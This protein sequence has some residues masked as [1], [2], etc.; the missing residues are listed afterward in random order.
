MPSSGYFISTFSCKTSG[1]GY[2]A[3][4]AEKQPSIGEERQLS[5]RLV[6]ASE[7]FQKYD[8]KGRGF[9][10]PLQLA[11]VWA[12]DAVAIVSRELNCEEKLMVASAVE[13]RFFELS[14]SSTTHVS[15]EE[16]FHRCL[17]DAHP[18]GSA[19]VRA[20]ADKARELDED[21][22][23]LTRDWESVD[24]NC[25]GRVFEEDLEDA[26]SY[27][28]V[29]WLAER[30][31]RELLDEAGSHGVT[32]ADFCAKRL[33]LEWA[34]VELHFYD[35]SKRFADCLSPLLLG[36]HEEGIWHTSVVAFGQEYFYYG[37]IHIQNP[38][39]T[40][41]GVP[42]RTLKLGKTLRNQDE[43]Q[44]VC[45]D[46]LP[47]FQPELYDPLE[48]NC[49]DLS[50]KLIYY[51]LGRHIPNSVRFM[52]DRLRR[53]SVVNAVKPILGGLLGGQA[54]EDGGE[55]L[56]LRTWTGE[57]SRL[58]ISEDVLVVDIPE[59]SGPVVAQLVQTN[60]DDTMDIKWLDTDGHFRTKAGVCTRDI[61]PYRSVVD[62]A[63]LEF[64]DDLASDLGRKRDKRPALNRLS[65]KVTELQ[66]SEASSWDVTVCPVGHLLRSKE[67][68]RFWQ[69]RRQRHACGLCGTAIP[70]SDLRM[71]CK[72]CKYHV[73][74][75]CWYRHREAASARR[76]SGM[77]QLSNAYDCPKGHALERLVGQVVGV[78]A[79]CASCK[80]EELGSTTAYFFCCRPCRYV[81][82]PACVES[83][84]DRRMSIS[85]ASS[86]TTD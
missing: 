63:R 39:T 19:T 13:R 3:S 51:L 60:E 23:C 78:D 22:G 34:D 6:N 71:R 43:F 32:Y 74:Q 14:V 52:S 30:D 27:K 49:N 29:N 1:G 76:P 36:H 59:S 61:R 58:D 4:A 40:C 55:F 81:A 26:L 73:C 45:E 12:A 20:I 57:S 48:H 65:S 72:Q 53:S 77:S 62:T 68:M 69:G 44:K 31:L 84:Q 2:S 18:P 42:N 25:I 80:K 79:S 67:Y 16:W 82:C 28:T 75:A 10:Q 8:T 9:I 66:G 83:V 85:S 11:K 54:A 24:D 7:L 38:G 56:R 86:L 64:R 21:V 33:G 37:K 47:Q 41:F 70:R 15:R 5:E 50:D 17:L 35:L 46:L